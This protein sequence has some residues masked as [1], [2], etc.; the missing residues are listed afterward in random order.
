MLLDSPP[1][2]LGG[3]E[4]PTYRHLIKKVNN[5]T[6][7]EDYTGFNPRTRTSHKGEKAVKATVEQQQQGPQPATFTRGGKG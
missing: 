2:L 7:L 3:H 1:L 6:D 5:H 4:T